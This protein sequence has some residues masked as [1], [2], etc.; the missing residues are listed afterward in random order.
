MYLRDVEMVYFNLCRV[1]YFTKAEMTEV[2]ND[3]SF[4]N[5]LY[6]LLNKKV[7]MSHALIFGE[8][9]INDNIG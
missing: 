6:L 1:D 3:K 5:V 7:I 8:L 4:L 2:A 9:N